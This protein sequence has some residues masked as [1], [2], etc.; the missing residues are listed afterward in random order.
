M[1]VERQALPQMV[2]PRMIARP[3]TM[4]MKIRGL[5]ETR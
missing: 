2:F 5:Q 3:V 1:S 4:E